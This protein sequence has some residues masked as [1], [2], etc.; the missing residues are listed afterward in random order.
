MAKVLAIN[1]KLGAFG[2]QLLRWSV[3]L[4]VKCPGG[5]L[6]VVSCRVPIQRA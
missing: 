5:Q 1:N 2:G 4:A 6:A 3:C